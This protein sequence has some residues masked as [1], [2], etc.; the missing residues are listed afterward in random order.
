MRLLDI[1]RFDKDELIGAVIHLDDTP[2]SERTLILPLIRERAEEIGCTHDVEESIS[3]L[4]SAASGN[5]LHIAELWTMPEELSPPPPPSFSCEWLP[6]IFGEYAAELTYVYQVPSDLPALL[7]LGAVSAAAAKLYLIVPYA[8]REEQTQLFT[9]V[10]LPPGERKSPVFKEICRPFTRWEREENAR[11]APLIERRKT[12]REV[13]ERAKRKAIEKAEEA[14]ALRLSDELLSLPEITPVQLFASDATPES[15]APLLKDNGE[16]IALMDAE[17]GIFS[18]IAG[19]YNS[20]KSDFDTLLHGYNS[21]TIRCNRIGRGMITVEHP[22]ITA[23]LTVQP[24]VVREVFRN[25]A[26]CERGLLGRFLWA[27]PEPK[28]GRRIIHETGMSEETRA[29]YDER[30]YALLNRPRPQCPVPLMLTAQARTYFHD[31]SEELERR[32]AKGGDLEGLNVWGWSSKLAGN[33]LR[34]A[35][36][37]CIMKELTEIDA[38]A[39]LTAIEISRWAIEHARAVGFELN[40]CGES[41]A[42]RV[43]KKIIAKGWRAGF[44]ES[45]LRQSGIERTASFRTGGRFDPRKLTGAL[46]ELEERGYLRKDTNVY[47][48]GT[49]RKEW[50]YVNPHVFKQKDPRSEMEELTKWFNQSAEST[51]AAQ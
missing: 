31:W 4:Q 36:A 5:D 46:E 18:T 40:G 44:S 26:M 7:I 23:V 9:C 24:N 42:Q 49:R 12:E 32:Q 34:I 15:L 14:E 50:Y 27:Q 3:L 17:G 48:D 38:S 10:S 22:N 16:R 6:G 25:P 29:A 43:L 11:R 13:R 28:V 47:V 1:A 37:L 19:K 41:N 45:T 8:G 21:E 33:T 51:H 2:P 30:I 20:G 39:I 35:A